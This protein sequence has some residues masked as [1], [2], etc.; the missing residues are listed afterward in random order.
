MKSKIVVGSRVLILPAFAFDFDGALNEMC[1]KEVGKMAT[2]YDLFDDGDASAI[3]D[4]GE[5][6]RVRDVDVELQESA[7]QSVHPTW[8]RLGN[9]W[10]GSR[11]P[12]G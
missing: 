10:T 8:G 11:A 3:I 2:I 7:Q 6:V 9:F 5:M 12:R 1:E 4:D